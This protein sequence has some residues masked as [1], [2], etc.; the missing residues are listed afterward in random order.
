MPDR[1]L[2]RRRGWSPGTRLHMRERSGL[3]IVTADTDGVLTIDGQGHV[4][5]AKV[6]HS[7]RLLVGQVL[8]WPPILSAAVIAVTGVTALAG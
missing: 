1:A 8:R 3:L 4:V 2:T 7:C 5:P 6:R